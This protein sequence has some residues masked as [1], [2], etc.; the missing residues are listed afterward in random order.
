MTP[1][2]LSFCFNKEINIANKY[3]FII[4]ETDIAKSDCSITGP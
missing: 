4:A 3:I 2:I 1:Y